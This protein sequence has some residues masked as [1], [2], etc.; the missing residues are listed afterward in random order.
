[1]KHLFLQLI[2]KLLW[3]LFRQG[4]NYE[5]L[6]NL[7]IILPPLIEQQQIAEFL[8]EKCGEVD[9]LIALQER[10]IGE[11]GRYKQSVITEAVTRGL[12]PNAPLKDSGI[13]WIGEIPKH[14]ELISIKRCIIRSFAG[15]WG[16]DAQNN[17]NDVRCFRVA[18]FNYNQLNLTNNNPTN[19]NI[20][21]NTFNQRKVL[22]G[23]ILL[24][25]SGGGEKTPVGRAV[26]VDI[27]ED[28]I[29]SNFVHCI[30]VDNNTN[31]KYLVYMFS[32]MYSIK[33][34][35]LYINQT[36]GIQ[37]LNVSDYL[38]NIISRPPLTEQQQIADYL[39]QKCS[40]IDEMTE[41]KKRKIEHL[42]EYKKSLIYE[43]VTGKKQLT[44]Q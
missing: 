15:I 41:I 9:E 14:W 18:D 29:C 42:K 21:K 28:S 36:T 6:R 35:V 1:M 40:E 3:R 2:Q 31:S 10:M 19:R 23:D 38:N 5:D 13:D 22:V 11:L 17:D 25:K 30:K 39:D 44:N 43:Y 27:K 12:D 32:N 4:M 34:N 37:N 20:D 16:E 33:V 26:Y 24:E 7:R 8:D